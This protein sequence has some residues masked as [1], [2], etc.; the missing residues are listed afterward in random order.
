MQRLQQILKICCPT[1]SSFTSSGDAGSCRCTWPSERGGARIIARAE[2][3][4]RCDFLGVHDT[5]IGIAPRTEVDLRAFSSDAGTARKVWRHRPSAFFS[6]NWR[7]FWEV[8]SVSRAFRSEGSSFTLYFAAGLYR[9]ST[10]ELS[11][12]G[13]PKLNAATSSLA[14][15]W[16]RL[17]A[18]EHIGR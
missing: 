2:P 1:H 15:R 4:A 3:C 10:A 16:C 12:S 18:E 14:L 5:A 11:V 17:R 7:R 6:G 8:R 9:A 13:A